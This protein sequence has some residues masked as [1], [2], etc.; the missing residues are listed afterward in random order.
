MQRTITTNTRIAH[1]WVVVAAQND[2]PKARGRNLRPL[3]SDDFE[4]IRKIR[5]DIQGAWAV[6][7]RANEVLDEKNRV[8][9]YDMRTQMLDGWQR[10]YRWHQSTRETYASI[11]STLVNWDQ[12]GVP[13]E[14]HDILRKHL[15][16]ADLFLRHLKGYGPSQFY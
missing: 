6:Q 14:H 10:D 16:G 8:T 5:R 7:K 9:Y 4:R 2:W 1:A 3:T 11:L 13:Q 15:P 12:H